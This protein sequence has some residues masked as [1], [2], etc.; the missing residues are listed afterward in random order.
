M[1][2]LIQM[3]FALTK[4]V[5]ICAK[6]TAHITSVLVI[7]LALGCAQQKPVAQAPV[8]DVAPLISDDLL[9]P[10]PNLHTEGIPPIQKSLAERVAAYT[11]FRGT[12][13]SDW[14]P[15]K[16]EM[17]VRYRPKNANIAQ[18]YWLHGPGSAQEQ[19]TDF[20][21]AVSQATFD[22]REGKFVAFARDS[23]GNEATRIFRLDLDTREVTPLSPAEMKSEYLWNRK[24]DQ[25]LVVS[26]PLDRTADGGKRDNIGTTLSLV[27]PLKPET[28]RKIAELP[29]AGWGP[30]TFA[31]DEKS[32]VVLQYRSA[33]DSAVWRI[34]LGNGAREQ[35]LPATK[36]KKPVSYGGFEISRDGKTLYLVTDEFGEF[37]ELVAYNFASKQLTRMRNIPWDVRQFKLSEDGKRMLVINSSDGAEAAHVFDLAS[38]KELPHQTVPA[39]AIG[40][41]DWHAKRQAELAFSLTSPQ[42]PGDVYSMDASNGKVER[43]TTAES[44]G[45]DPSNFATPEMIRW[46]SFDGRIISGLLLLPPDKFKGPRPV[47]I[48]IHGGPESQASVRFYGRVNYLVEELG[49]AV[50]FPN[51][52]G[53]S[54]YGKTFLDLDNG[55]KR[56]DSVR[57][58]G[59]LFDWLPS[60][61][62]LDA[63]RVAV[64]GGSYGG[65]M[66]LAVAVQY[67]DRIKGAIDTVGISN[68]VSFLNR[69]ES[70][71]RDLR[72]AEYGDERDPK[73]RAFLE[74]ISPLNH[75]ER[76]KVPL[77]V[78]HGRNDPRVPVA[79]A[80]QIVQKVRANGTPVWYLM[81]DNEGHGFARKNNADFAFYATVKFLESNLLDAR[82]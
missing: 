35:L 20:P 77:L 45:V 46:K 33:T 78:V 56:E 64:T 54:G 18:L 34:N 48:D 12:S 32:L 3:P 29:G 14:H 36:G 27:D 63:K 57:D 13:F 28:T 31:P 53:S 75:A 7:A 74:E 65:Y 5:S 8:A 79:E 44:D 1:R 52:R 37:K 24:G 4:A 59:S 73:M 22:P 21:D 55:I 70:Y 58:I 68:F 10:N 81:A 51:V 25:M 42:S 50:L 23:G 11:E 17:L 71:R 76:I 62:R 6:W 9:T 66:S 15:L 41:V 26:V 19:L 38:G 16:R 80:E 43:W 72:R 2:E 60:Q 82:H 47:L 30:F 61:H 69:T 40:H 39:G 67:S 49:I